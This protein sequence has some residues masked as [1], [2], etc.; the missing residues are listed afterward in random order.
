MREAIQQ[1]STALGRIVDADSDRETPR[2]DSGLN[3][4]PRFQARRHYTALLKDKLTSAG[5]D[6][7]QALGNLQN[8]LDHAGQPPDLWNQNYSRVT[9]AIKQIAVRLP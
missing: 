5:S 4:N 8:L 9:A 3:A 1:S 6:A 2:L 7:R